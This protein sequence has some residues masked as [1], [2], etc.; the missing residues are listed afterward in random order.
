M[1]QRINQGSLSRIPLRI[2]R[3]VSLQF[4]SSKGLARKG[5]VGRPIPRL[6]QRL[7][8]FFFGAL[9][10]ARPTRRSLIYEGSYLT[11][12]ERI[13]L[14]KKLRFIGFT[15]IELLVV[16][17]IIAILAGLLLP[18]LGRAK[19]KA[20]GISCLNNLKQLM[21]IW[22]LYANDNEEQTVVNN[23]GTDPIWTRTW[24]GGSFAGH[25]ED[26]TNIFL[27]IDPKRALFGPYLKTPTIYRCPSDKTI[28]TIH[29]RKNRLV[30]SY[31]MNSHVGWR[32][33]EYRGQPNRGFRVFLKTTDFVD[34]GPSATFVFMEI[35]PKSICRPFFGV[36]MTRSA[37][38]HI[39]ANYHRPASTVAFADG[40]AVLHRWSDPRTLNPPRN[41]HW[42]GHNYVTPNNPDIRWIQT[43]TTSRR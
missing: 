20:Q 41:L 15:L 43:H 24:V 4:L 36:H 23:N 1:R 35:H 2:K 21:I 6:P 27:L 33:S 16:I 31:G 29:G 42:H 5:K 25:P 28:V 12:A 7:T 14:P 32:G 18:A 8:S 9:R 30:R 40:H 34:P 13:S 26:S 17:A 39:P 19:A 38:Y 11:N 22:T 10:T 37:F 3:M